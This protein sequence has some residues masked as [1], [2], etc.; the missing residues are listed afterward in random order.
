[1]NQKRITNQILEQTNYT[2]NSTLNYLFNISNMKKLFSYL[3]IS[4]MVVLSSCTNYDD[5][6][7]DL[8]TQIN[9]LKSQIEGFSSLSSGLT[10]LQGTVASLQT[11]IANIP[12]TPA[13]DVS[14]LATAA[15]LTAL[16]TALT[17][18]AAEVDALTTALAN[19]ATSAEV[20]A[21][22]TALTTQQ[23]NL[24]ELLAANNV[25]SASVTIAS[26]ADLDFAT[27][28]GNKVSIINGDLDITQT[29]TMDAAQL[30]T[31]MGK[32]G[33]VTGNVAYT[34][35]ISTVTTASFTKLTGSKKLTIAQTGD[36][37]LP[38]Y[39]QATDAFSITGDDLTTSVSLPKFNAATTLA[40][41][42]LTKA[43][44]FSMPA[45]AVHDGDISISIANTGSVDL[46]AL[47]NSTTEAGAADTSPDDLTVN[48][49][50]LTAP[51]YDAG[52][53][54]ADRLTDVNLPKW[55]YDNGSSFDRA[56]TV[57]L[58]SVNNAK[59]AAYEIDINATFPK[60]TSV[61]LI[62]A[63]STATTPTHLDVTT[64]GSDNL[65]TLILGG[66]WDD[67]VVN[68]TDLTSL[69]FDGTAM[70][71]E[72]SS[73]DIVTLD[74]PY[75]SA[76]KGTL[77]IDGNLDMTSVTA[78]KVDGL[79][80]LTITG[81]TEL[82][83]M[84]FAALKT[85]A[86][87]ANATITGN[88]FA[89]KA[90]YTSATAYTIATTSG[91][92]ELKTF[93][94]AVVTARTGT[95]AMKVELDDATVVDSAGA[96]TTPDPYYIVD[97]KDAVTSGGA[98]AVA[99]QI[100]YTVTPNGSTGLQL[101]VGG[102]A[103]YVNA[104]GTATP[105]V[106]SNNS[107]LAI[108]QLKSASAVSRADALGLVLD[109]VSGAAPKA[110]TVSFTLAT[111]STTGES[112]DAGATVS[113]TL[114]GADDYAK[115]TIGS[116]SVTATSAASN[117]SSTSGIAKALA[118]AWSTKYGVNSTLYTLNA[119]TNSGIISISV[120]STIG[121]RAQGDTVSVE[122]F[123]G[124]TDTSTVPLLEY[125]IGNTGSAATATNAST[126]NSFDGEDLIILLKN[127]T[128]GVTGVTSPTI[129]FA[130]SLP[131]STLASTDDHTTAKKLTTSVV[132]S[133]EARGLA[134][135]AWDGTTLVIDTAASTTNRVS[136]L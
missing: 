47:T 55:K 29:K 57:V 95:V 130:T 74:I 11:A 12:V 68:G 132:W 52:K 9:T 96:E 109:V 120:S 69:T 43:T 100:A 78:S 67:V 125:V 8:N 97:L 77:K 20:A 93:L 131:S 30:A 35:T 15:N 4:S 50:T 66:T 80:G 128:A 56:L 14:G 135:N 72:V 31:L 71:V 99:R 123:G 117:A 17:A 21:L 116:Q 106:P 122:T 119:D 24:N 54:T 114:I 121:N 104:A 58:P 36:I 102:D 107:A 34:A 87:A 38:L 76:A 134:I 37:S 60:A 126:D 10:A 70:D 40:F 42:G 59:A 32:V 7:D 18:L 22:Q 112:A 92:K 105:I 62:A 26:Q 111:N 88:K 51:L 75:T 48:A 91:L 28:L 44:S 79:K 73:T 86:A 81:N 61:H 39:V 53:I 27:A 64:G 89:G 84:S 3:L 113:T 129:V 19:A 16:D 103:L 118:D 25:Y 101:T 83:S 45:L 127:K 49:A 5:Q 13:T 94:G 115:L 110:L 124:T 46:S 23:A 98:D 63:A 90:T 136:K 85:A 6:F 33:S 133:N 1:M 2:L 108:A 41:A 82:S 65:N